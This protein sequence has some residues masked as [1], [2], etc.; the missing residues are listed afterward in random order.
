[1]AI[2]T[3][4][5]TILLASSPGASASS[6]SEAR[7]A[8]TVTAKRAEVTPAFERGELPTEKARRVREAIKKGEYKLARDTIGEVL[9]ASS[10]KSWRFDPF[11][12]F[13][14]AV[15]DVA[16][17]DFQKRLDDWNASVD[18]DPIP[19]L[20]RA[21]YYADLGWF[22]RG[23]RYSNQVLPEH[24]QTA[25]RA[26]ARGA[27]DIALSIKRDDSNPYAFYLS[28]QLSRMIGN[29]EERSAA[30]KSGQQRH[31]AYY[32]LYDAA[33][34]M[35]QPKWGGSVEAMREFVA[36]YAGKAPPDSPLK[37]L[38]VSYYRYLLIT[39]S[40]T[41]GSVERDGKKE[42]LGEVLKLASSAGLEADI[43]S[44][45]RL[46]DRSDKYEFGVVVSDIVTG[47]LGLRDADRQSGAFL[48]ILASTMGAD[49]TLEPKQKEHAN[50]IVDLAVAKSWLEKG[51]YENALKKAEQARNN[52]DTTSE[53]DNEKKGLALGKVYQFLTLLKAKQGDYEETVAYQR[54]AKLFGDNTVN[55]YRACFAYYSLKEYA[56]AVRECSNAIADNPSS[57]NARFWRALSKE[58]SG[59]SEGAVA[60]LEFVAATENGFR[61]NAA[62][63]LSMIAFKRNDLAGALDVLQR[64]TYLYDTK[65]VERADV[66]VAYNNLCYAQME[67]KAFEK[68]LDA[69]T[70]SLRYGD[71]PDAYR[72]QQELVR[73]TAR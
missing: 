21:Q 47:M 7:I 33:L 35:L 37:M 49:T 73:L 25:G 50:Y 57:V 45:L 54:L 61:A 65:L 2:L 13:I 23:D 24:M 63:Q 16:D 70:Q 39:A 43:L 11:E 40:N 19:P 53:F 8:Q 36:E 28:L 64:Y 56:A 29:F 1:M 27:E 46:Y 6:G 15:P 69:C 60:D 42:C 20:V 71:L 14:A 12:D 68:A 18:A 55:G 31:P 58:A 3:A 52:L 41:C 44:G 66:A 5:L 30:F 72:K 10:L 51:F 26:F 62:I 48:Q 9:A 22:I 67:L 34:A 59:D 32:K 4:A 17:P 38:H